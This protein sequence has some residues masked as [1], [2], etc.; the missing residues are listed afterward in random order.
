M[1]NSHLKKILTINTKQDTII[2]LIGKMDLMEQYLTQTQPNLSSFL[3][4]YK[5]VTETI[6]LKQINNS[7]YFNNSKSLEKLDLYFARLYFDKLKK[8]LSTNQTTHPWKAHFEY[9]NRK[10]SKAIVQIFTGI[11]THINGDLLHALIE[12]KYNQKKDFF[13][14]N[15]ILLEL[16]PKITSYLAFEKHDF[17]GLNAY[18]FKDLTVKEFN[19]TIVKWR[20][21]TWEN[22][23]NVI[24][25]KQEY[26]TIKSKINKETNEANKKIIDAFHSNNV[27]NK[28]HLLQILT[29]VQPKIKI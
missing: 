19:E 21:N 28:L 3:R 23:Q 15:E 4:T 7:K 29:L 18:I 10:D 11:N 5:L 27:K 17:Y 25:S 16:T 9:C 6:L 26:K 22:Y 14:V 8:Y 13:K 2:N 24:Q 1:L 12:T 20:K